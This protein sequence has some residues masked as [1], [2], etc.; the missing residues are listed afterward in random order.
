M[1]H[2]LQIRDDASALRGG[3]SGERWMNARFRVP[4]PAACT[5]AAGQRQNR[6]SGPVAQLTLLLALFA[7]TIVLGPLAERLKL[8][9]P[10]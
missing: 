7:A 1:T 6:P 3:S 5:A 2:T 8:P 9:Y 10:V 4:D